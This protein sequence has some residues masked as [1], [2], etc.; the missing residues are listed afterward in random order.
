MKLKG[1]HALTPRK[2]LVQEVASLP[3]DVVSTKE[4]RQLSEGKPHS[5]LRVVRAEVWFPEP[6]SPYEDRVYA[7]AVEQFQKMQREGILVQREQNELFLYRQIWKGH[8]QRGLT[9]LCHVEDYEN[10]IIKKHEK[11][12]QDKEDD[13]TR[14]IRETRAQQGPVFLTYRDRSEITRRMD[15]VEANDTPL[16]DYTAEDGIRHTV[17][18]LSDVNFWINAFAKV[19][20][21]YVADG[22][23]RSA[24]AV[25]VARELR[26]ANPNHTGNEEYNWFLSVLFPASE[27]RILP[28]HRLILDWGKSSPEQLQQILESKFGAVRSDA[29]I[30]EEKGVAGAYFNGQWW[31]FSLPAATQTS[32][33]EELEA[34][35]LYEHLLAPVLSIGDPRTDQRIAFVGG[36]RGIPGLTGPVDQGDAVVAFA[37]PAVTLD[38]LMSIADAG[39]IMPPKTTWFEP[40]LRTGLF[41]HTF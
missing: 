8:S 24:S 7:K 31:K 34:S 6:V 13:R 3:Y 14:L 39:E 26:N 38:D 15:D 19:D 22:H 30:P 18:A 36:I 41:M 20:V 4:A 9:G 32:P 28:Y 12:R 11:T 17:W 27:L 40:K 29:F 37:L 16:F 1:Y 23:H 21:A 5:M 33:A 2:D 25:R 35:R 10:D